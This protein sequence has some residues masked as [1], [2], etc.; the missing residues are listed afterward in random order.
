VSGGVAKNIGVIK[1][2]EG[3]LGLKAH[4]APEPQIVRAL[5]AALFASDIC[6]DG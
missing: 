5:G 6:Q 3:K 2:A 1:R 4:I